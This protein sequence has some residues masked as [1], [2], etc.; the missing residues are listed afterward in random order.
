MIDENMN[1]GIYYFFS[2]AAAIIG[3]PFIGLAFDLTGNQILLFPISLIFFILALIS[4]FFVKS[5]IYTE[6]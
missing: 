3:P 4:M 1:T 2:Q 6:K 5:S